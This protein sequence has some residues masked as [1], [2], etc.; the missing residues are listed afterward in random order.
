MAATQRAQ[1]A[2]EALL[3]QQSA[4]SDG[5]VSDLDASA[6]LSL[7]ERPVP[8]TANPVASSVHHRVEYRNDLRHHPDRGA[9]YYEYTRARYTRASLVETGRS[10]ARVHPLVHQFCAPSHHQWL[11]ACW[12][13]ESKCGGHKAHD[14]GLS[15]MEER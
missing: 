8:A 1:W 14:I 2:K 5:Y 6:Y 10:A 11:Q 3:P 9:G 13:L 7:L 4:N 15:H 12:A